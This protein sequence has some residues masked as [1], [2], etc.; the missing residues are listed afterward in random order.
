LTTG[1]TSKP[2]TTAPSRRA[3]AIACR[4]HGAG[5]GHQHRQ[6]LRQPVGR[7]HDRLVAG[8]RRLGGERIHRLRARDAGNRLHGERRHAHRR[9]SL[10]ALL[11][12]QRLEK[13][14]QDL[15]VPQ[16]AQLLLARLAHLGDDFR[17]PRVAQLGARLSERVVREGRSLAGT[18]LHD[19]VDPRFRELRDE[20]GDERD[21]P[22]ARLRLLRN[23]DPH[24]SRTLFPGRDRGHGIEHTESVGS[25][26]RLSA[27]IEARDPYA[28]GHSS[29][30]TVF[31]QAM[32]RRM[33]LDKERV[34]T[35]RLGALLHDV[36]KLA[37]PS[38]VL[39]KRGPLTEA[40]F[41]QMRRHP[42]AGARMLE[43]LGAPPILP[44]VLHH[45]ERWDGA[46]Y[47][48]G[49]QAEQIPLEA[50]VLCIADSFDAMTSTRPYRAP[51]RPDEALDELER[52]AGTQFDPELVDAF[53]KAWAEAGLG[54]LV[55]QHA[56]AS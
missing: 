32:A 25:L 15:P 36:G 21:P 16:A 31:A 12:G 41:G 39:L 5:C 1:R 11:V 56:A 29:R 8:D 19:D 52:C 13:A 45:H 4:R 10:D 44:V 33:G 17:G 46:G 24:G 48:T 23:A 2:D 3:V 50:R 6:E 26:A 47:P 27:A 34:S 14:D 43:T 22:L 7:E 28:R 51:R 53:A 35:L 40:E 30:V 55:W 37:V 54:A 18:G 9:E 38:S 42:A 20:L 49:R